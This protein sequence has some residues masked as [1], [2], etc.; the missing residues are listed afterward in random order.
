MYVAITRAKDV[1]F[2]S[3]AHSRMTRWQTKMNPPSRFLDEISPDLVKKYDLSGWWSDDE[4]RASV[5]EWDTVKHKLF[6]TGYV[7]EV[8]NNLAIVKFHNPKFGV[9]KI[10]M[11][12][13]Q[14]A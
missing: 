1:L 2:L 9:R 5:D 7:L 6:G 10:E 3:H 12:F 4:P 11:R 14:Q 13:L 8:W